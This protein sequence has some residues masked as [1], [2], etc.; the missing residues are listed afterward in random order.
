[1]TQP[2]LD[3]FEAGL[4]SLRCFRLIDDLAA[5]GVDVD[6]SVLASEAPRPT[7][8][9]SSGRP[10]RRPDVASAPRPVANKQAW[11][12]STAAQLGV[13]F[14]H[15]L[16]PG[17]PVCTTAELT[18]L[19]AGIETDR[20]IDALHETYRE[21]EQLRVRLRTGPTGPEQQVTETLPTVAV[22]EVADRAAADDWVEAAL[23]TPF[24]LD[25]G[26]VVRTAILCVAGEPRWWLHA[27]HHVVLD[28]Y[29]F[30]RL[31]GRVGDH[32]RGA[33]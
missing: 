16:R 23:A 31:A 3:L 27:A 9:A 4:D 2:E 8:S 30:I 21:G 20:L 5:V 19:P 15:Q 26:E 25:A 7:C 6:F 28:G 24:D 33:S 17:M 22:V 29:G 11:L 18:T 13:Y 32:Y 14:L 1:M 10:A 12:P